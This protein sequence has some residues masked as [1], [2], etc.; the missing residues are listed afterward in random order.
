LDAN[1][2]TEFAAGLIGA[3]IHGHS[4]PLNSPRGLL[5]AGVC[6]AQFSEPSGRGQAES[7]W[8]E[9]DAPPPPP[10]PSTDKAAVFRD[11]RDVIDRQLR[12]ACVFD[13]AW[14]TAPSSAT[15]GRIGGAPL[16]PVDF[17]WPVSRGKPLRFIAQLPLAH[18]SETGIG[19]FLGGSDSLLTIFWDDRYELPRCS[20]GEPICV[21]SAARSV[22]RDLPSEFLC[23]A[24]AEVPAILLNPEL[25][26]EVPAWS[27]VVEILHRELGRLDERLLQAFHREEW[28]AFPHPSPLTKLGG[29]PHWIQ[30]PSFEG[31]FLAQLSGTHGLFDGGMLYIFQ[32]RDRL[33]AELHDD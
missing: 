14:A 5:V 18:A 9:V 15:P 25:V 4:T 27:E 30:E 11:I 17:P 33:H 2:V 7:A 21:V 31:R 24:E 10:P 1:D 28:P 32:G 26:S 3:A 8:C 23:S 13:I 19:E 20:V 6:G 16:L 29:W 12:R 22:P